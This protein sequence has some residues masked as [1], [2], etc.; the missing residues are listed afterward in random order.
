[1][2][3]APQEQQPKLVL[4]LAGAL[5]LAGHFHGEV[6][7]VAAAVLREYGDRLDQEALGTIFGKKAAQRGDHNAAA[8]TGGAGEEVEGSK[9]EQ[10]EEQ[11]DNDMDEEARGVEPRVV[12]ERQHICVLLKP[13]GWTVSVDNFAFSKEQEP[14]ADLGALPFWA[15]EGADAEAAVQPQVGGRRALQAWIAD[16]FGP[17]QPLALDPLTGHGLVHRLDRDTSGLLLCARTYRGF[18]AAQLEL[19]ARR[20]RKEYVCLCH[21]HLPLDLRLLEQPLAEGAFGG[22]AWRTVV[23]AHGRA[24]K[25]EILA[26]CRCLDPTGAEFSLVEVLLHTGRLHQIRAHLAH[27]GHALVGDAWYADSRQQPA[28]CERLFLHSHRLCVDLRA[29]EAGAPLDVRA[30]LPPELRAAL[31][32]LRPAHGTVPGDAERL[33]TWRGGGAPERDLGG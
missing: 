24:S 11:Q 18:F 4:G 20:V 28:W 15:G 17:S 26:A 22:E 33:S 9:G 29:G 13:A 21:G 10:Q 14:G 1:M 23:A 32:R 5:A 27:A 6:E 2:P 25:T 7:A 3:D 12:L 8:L 30:G 31:R 16:T 19:H